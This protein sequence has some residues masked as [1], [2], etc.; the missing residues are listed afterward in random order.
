MLYEWNDTATEF[1]ADKCVQELFEEQVLR[2]PD[3][4]AVVFE[5]AELSYAELNRRAN[6]LAHYLGE[7]GVRPDARVAICVERGFQMVVALLAVLKAGG[8]YVPLDPA[9]PAERLRFML[10]DSEPVALLTQ[11]HL[12][13][14]FTEPGHALPVLD[15]DHPAWGE[16]PETNPDPHDIG[17]TPGHLA[18]VI[19]TSGST[20]LPKGVMVQHRGLC[21]LVSVQIR[22]FAVEIDSRVLQFAS[23]SF[24]ACVSEVLMA[25]CRGASLYLPRQGNVLVGET[26]IQA[27]AG[28]LLTRPCRRQ[29]WRD[30]RTVS[31]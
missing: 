18:Y 21:N 19:Y 11:G 4:T 7:L 16:R 6:Q 10:E 31:I 3:A 29:C 9:Y 22:D 5:D 28:P 24:D 27:I 12:R 25:L 1:P 15:L 26:L 13:R 23:F 2:S 14:L 17:L 30:Y 8:A 20:G